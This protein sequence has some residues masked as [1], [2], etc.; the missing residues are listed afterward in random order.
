MQDLVLSFPIFMHIQVGLQERYVMNRS[1]IRCRSVAD[2]F[3]LD[4]QQ[5]R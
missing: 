4:S 3:P 1:V 2:G 5:M